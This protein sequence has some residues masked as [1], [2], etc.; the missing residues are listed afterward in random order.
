MFN[1][2]ISF[3]T[4]RAA[5]RLG[6]L[7]VVGGA[8][9]WLLTLCV[10]PSATAQCDRPEWQPGE[11]LRGFNGVVRA[12]TLWD[13]DGAGGEPPVLV[14]AGAFSI[15]GNTFANNIAMWNGRW[16]EP[17]GAGTPAG[18]N[19][20]IWSL[21]TL[22]N[23]DLVAGGVFQRAGDGLASRVARWNGSTWSPLGSGMGTLNTTIVRALAV[24][25]SGD[26]VAAGRFINAGGQTVANI[27]RWNGS[28]WSPLGSGLGG[29]PADVN[30]L[31][32]LP[33]GNLV[34][35]GTFTTAGGAA[36]SGVARWDGANWL[37]LGAGL[38]GNVRGLARLPNGD[39]LAVGKMSA[40]GN[41]GQRNVLRWDGTAWAALNPQAPIGPDSQAVHVT[42]EGVIVVGH[43]TI[44]FW[45]GVGW[46]ALGG[47]GVGT[48]YSFCQLP[49]GDLV[50]AGDFLAVGGLPAS[51]AGTRIQASAIARWDGQRW[52]YFGSG[53]GGRSRN[54]IYA[55]LPLPEG[56]VIAGGAFDAAGAVEAVN[57][58]R[59]NGRQ[60]S[61]LP[62]TGQF[63]GDVRAL[64]LDTDG[65]VLAGG[66]FTE[67]GGRAARGIARWNGNDWFPLG[68]DVASGTPVVE[69]LAVLPGGDVV[70]CGSFSSLGGVN[71]RGLAR[72]NGTTWAPFG[73]GILGSAS[74]LA[75]MSNGDLVVGG[76]ITSVDG[77]TVGRLARW[78]GTAWSGFGSGMNGAVYA[79]VPLPD[80]RLLA[81]GRF[82]TAG[83]VTASRVALWDGTTWR[84]LG[85]GIPAI[86]TPQVN[87]LAVLA[88]GEVIVGG[89]FTRAGT[90]N[91]ANLARWDG[92]SWSALGSGTGGAFDSSVYALAAL[93]D[94][95]FVVGGGFAALNDHP[96]ALFAHWGCPAV[97]SP[98]RIAEISAAG[99][100]VRFRFSGAP[101]RTYAVEHAPHL[102]QWTR[103][104]GGLDGEAEF[105]DTDHGRLEQ[106]AGFYRVVEE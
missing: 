29:N 67:A 42:P 94:G 12:T 18:V 51:P 43:A 1:D 52:N 88:N 89:N 74:C 32:V 31:L 17:L 8:L 93:G 59:W 78:N 36:I 48:F 21:A 99:R 86:S 65:Q 16:W 104:Q 105:E 25:P 80:N 56:G 11:A 5:R 7:A 34:A 77:V 15:A 76:E 6:C 3:H 98:L 68:T 30:A 26:L 41:P 100:A 101:G 19:G 39:L 45:N 38:S 24:L 87:A 61:A 69:A 66:A 44:W 54:H 9:T 2:L 49:D 10:S 28:A 23:G 13:R 82:G 14:A 95:G 70:A 64:A 73:S 79:L 62:Q 103:I 75:V 46:E 58:A 106:A 22:P 81:G 4:F 71:A 90:V 47:G 91:T 96:Q 33:D 20:E 27:A 84:P 40:L 55:L 53:F 50:A 63:N 72:W 83:G 57:V 92:V 35:G 37:P 85:P 60:W 102:N 97:Q